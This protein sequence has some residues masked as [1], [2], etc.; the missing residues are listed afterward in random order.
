MSAEKTVILGEGSVVV[1]KGSRAEWIS[2][3]SLVIT[4]AALVFNIGV[5]YQTVQD[6]DRRIIAEEAKSDQLIP[7]VE[8]IDANVAFLAEQAREQRERGLR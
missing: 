7:R 5:V 3:A 6:H 2:I 8:R 4:L 1:D